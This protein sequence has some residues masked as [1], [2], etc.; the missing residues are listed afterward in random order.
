VKL[1]GDLDSEEARLALVELVGGKAGWVA[2]V[3]GCSR[4]GGGGGLDGGWV[5]GWWGGADSPGRLGCAACVN[6]CMSMVCLCVGGRGGP[7]A[8]ADRLEQGRL[9]RRGLGSAAAVVEG[10]LAPMRAP[11]PP[12]RR[13]ARSTAWSARRRTPPRG[14]WTSWW[15]SSSRASASTPPSSA[16]TPRSCRPWPSGARGGGGLLAARRTLRPSACSGCPYISLNRLCL[17]PLLWPVHI[18]LACLPTPPHPPPPDPP[19]SHPHLQAPCAAGHDRA[20]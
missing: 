19:P 17:R 8:G 12:P 20:L 4:G 11:S 15:A 10:G 14:C 5:G 13:S 18:P 6:W 1:P 16:T 2:G 9:G 3:F 7:R